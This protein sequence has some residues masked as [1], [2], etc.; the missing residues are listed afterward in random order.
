MSKKIFLTAVFFIL[1]LSVFSISFVEI[2]LAQPK[3]PPPDKKDLPDNK[4]ISPET[5]AEQTAGMLKRDLNLTDEQYKQIYD[6]VYTYHTSH[7]ESTFDRDELN[8]EIE[9]VLTA[10][11]RD[12]FEMIKKEQERLE[13]RNK[14][15]EDEP[16]N[17]GPPKGKPP[18]GKPPG[19]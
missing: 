3:G 5:M 11:Q 14:K 2:S 18:R 4:E 8:S 7:N 19:N 17:D 12:K 15:S 9:S 6:I 16:P 10:E 13:K 1:L